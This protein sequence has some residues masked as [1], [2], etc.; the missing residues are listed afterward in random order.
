MRSL[1]GFAGLLMVGCATQARDAEIAHQSQY[2]PA[3]VDTYSEIESL[4]SSNAAL[5]EE[6]A[7]L[8]LRRRALEEQVDELRRDAAI[9]ERVAESRRRSVQAQLNMARRDLDRVRAE[10]G[11]AGADDAW[12]RAQG[13]RI[14]AY[15]RRVALLIS[16]KEL[17]G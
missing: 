10:R 16:L 15:E 2:R 6:V 8:E 3:I 9:N 4:R 17:L 7:T 1:Y 14:D 12:R 5:A 11:P 13:E